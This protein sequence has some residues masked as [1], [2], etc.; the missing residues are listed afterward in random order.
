MYY[1][2]LLQRKRADYLTSQE[3]LNAAVGYF[4][5]AAAHPLLED[6]VFQFQGAIVRDTQDKVRPFTKKGLA[7][8]IN[9]TEARLNGMRKRGEDWE[10]VL[11]LIE[12]VIFTQKF[13]NAAAG[14]LNANIISRDLGLAE[15]QETVSQVTATV[16]EPVEDAHVAVHIHPDDPDPLNLPRPMY[17]QAQ[18]AAGVPFTPLT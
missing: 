17:S 1:E 7:T 16:A 13:E 9:T 11:D 12:Q 18:I 3:L 4:E 6:K 10:H 15:K 8:H 2:R 5:W 14:L